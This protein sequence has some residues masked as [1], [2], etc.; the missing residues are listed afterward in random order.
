MVIID[1]NL[2][3][4]KCHTSSTSAPRKEMAHELWENH[5]CSAHGL[6]ARSRVS[7]MC[8]EVP[9]PLQ[10]QIFYLL[11]SIPLYGLRPTHLSGKPPRYSSLLKGQS[12]KTLS[13]GLSWKGLSQY[14]GPRQPSPRLAHLWRLRPHLDCSGPQTLCPRR[15]RGRAGRSRLCL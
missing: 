4:P 15:F 1:L 9:G 11:G 2:K 14:V 12:A 5:F 6:L 7:S 8:R 10:D 3:F 13:H